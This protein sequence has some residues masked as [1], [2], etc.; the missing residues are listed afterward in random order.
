MSG[1]TL[2]DRLTRRELLGGAGAGAA[3]LFLDPHSAGTDGA[4]NTVVFTHT[5]VANADAVRDD[6]ALA[7]DGDKIA[8][9]GPTDAVLKSY[10][11]AEVFD[12]RGKALFP[13]LI[14]C[15]AHMGAALERGFNEDFELQFRALAVRPGSLLPGEEATLMVT[16][17]ALEAIRTGTTT[18]V[19]NVGG[20]AHPRRRWRDR[21]ALR[22]RRV[23]RQREVAGPMSPEGLARGEPPSSRRSCA[24][25]GWGD[26]RLQRVARQQQ[27]PHQRVP[28]RRARRERVTRTA[29]GSP[30]VRRETRPRIHD[31]Y[32][33]E[34]RRVRVHGA[35]HG[36]AACRVSRQARLPRTA[37][38]R[39][40]RRYVDASEIAL[41]GRSRTIISHQAGWPPIAAS[42][43][44]FRRCEPPAAPSPSAPTTT[45]TMCSR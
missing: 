38:F 11:R 20:I 4:A 44:R 31:S 42:S 19:E 30:R 5:T 37:A 15:H 8:A 9:I 7:V 29:A 28:G 41:L 12:G 39:G 26:H 24:K 40:A 34:R 17:A 35:V 45:P 2:R 36:A 22:V 6:V 16:V 27:R 3:A 21:P 43:R 32:E 25:R 23:A 10:P 13:G 33:P 18:I 14:N 1:D